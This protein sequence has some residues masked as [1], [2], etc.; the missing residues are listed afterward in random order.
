[1]LTERSEN[2]LVKRP[3]ARLLRAM[4]TTL[5]GEIA[6]STRRRQRWAL[7]REPYDASAFR[8]EDWPE[9]LAS[10]LVAISTT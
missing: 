1:V 9:S 3:G 10:L 6:E 8:S 2:W 7:L 5:T 4:T